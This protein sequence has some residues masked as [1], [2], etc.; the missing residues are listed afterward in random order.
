[1]YLCC[2]NV[3]CLF[4]FCIDLLYYTHKHTQESYLIKVNFDM[5]LIVSYKIIL[6]LKIK[7]QF[8]CLCLFSYDVL[9]TVLTTDSTDV[10]NRP[11]LV[12]ELPFLTIISN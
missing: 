11:S 5:K 2:K 1:M 8:L 4:W 3:D 7:R 12:A 6:F 10:V 9:I